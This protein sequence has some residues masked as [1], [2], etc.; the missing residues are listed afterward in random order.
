MMST[1]IDELISSFEPDAKKTKTKY[2]QFLIHV[3][4][5]FDKRIKST[6]NKKVKEKYKKIRKTIL[7]YI[8]SHK[9]EI[10]KKLR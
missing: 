8:M 3:Y 5:T 2:D 6:D 7:S 4:F 9:P 1:L 10:I